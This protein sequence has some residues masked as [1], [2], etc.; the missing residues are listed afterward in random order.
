VKRTLCKVC[1]NSLYR[2][3]IIFENIF[4]LIWFPVGTVFG[5]IWLFKNQSHKRINTTET[6]ET[7]QNI[8][9]EFKQ[10][11]ENAEVQ[12]IQEVINAFSKNNL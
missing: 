9:N 10:Q 4:S 3:A 6:I 8:Q 11:N 2:I 12:K 7:L 1:R 5:F